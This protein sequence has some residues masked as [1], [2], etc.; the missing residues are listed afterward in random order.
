MIATLRHHATHAAK[1]DGKHPWTPLA[2]LV[3]TASPPKVIASSSEKPHQNSRAVTP[4]KV[5]AR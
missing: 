3:D 1:D 4:P 2:D 5:A